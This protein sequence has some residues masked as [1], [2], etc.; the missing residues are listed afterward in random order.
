MRQKIASFDLGGDRRV[1]DKLAVI[2]ARIEISGPAA[3]VEGVA[4]QLNAESVLKHLSVKRTN[5]SS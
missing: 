2:S 3:V 1:P 5:V 4:K